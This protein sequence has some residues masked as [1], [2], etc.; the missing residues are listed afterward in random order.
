MSHDAEVELDGISRDALHF[1]DVLVVRLGFYKET[2]KRVAMRTVG[3][4]SNNG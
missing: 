4:I 1:P 3:E 2:K